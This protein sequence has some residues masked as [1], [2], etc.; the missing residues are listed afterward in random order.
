MCYQQIMDVLNPIFDS[1]IAKGVG[2]LLGLYAVY[3]FGL[4]AYFLQREYEEVRGRYLDRG[5]DLASAQVEYA[6][7]V[8][9]SNW[10]LFLRYAKLCREMNAPFDAADFFQQFRELDQDQFQIAPVHR[11][12]AL[13]PNEVVWNQYQRVFSFVGTTNDKIKADFGPALQMLAENPMHPNRGAIVAE[14]EKLALELGDKSNEF[15]VYLS[16]LNNL[17]QI[18]ERE[19]IRRRD[20]TAFAAR[21]DVVAIVERLAAAYPEEKNA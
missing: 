4:R 1:P 17:A 2:A 20:L 10:S 21:K 19:R 15:Y 9:R 11:I 14:A 16:E 6:L 18:F 12:N 13:L 3:R 5:L 8:F 7:S